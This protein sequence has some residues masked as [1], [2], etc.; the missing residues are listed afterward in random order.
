MAFLERMVEIANVKMEE[1]VAFG[2][3]HLLCIGAVILLTFLL[4]R[5][6]KDTSDKG[7]RIII[8]CLWGV[9]LMFEIYK[10]VFD[11]FEIADGSFEYVYAWSDFPFQLCSTPLFVLPF[12]GFLSDGEVRDFFASYTMT[13]GLLGGVAVY[14][15]P[16]TVFNSSVIMNVQTMVHHGIQIISGV[17][18]AAYYRRS[19]KKRFFFRGIAVFAVLFAIANLFNT[20]GYDALVSAGLL[21]EGDTFN[22]FYISPRADQST[23]MFSDILKSLDPILYI[24]GYFVVVS[25][26]GAVLMY[27]EDLVY[28]LSRKRLGIETMKL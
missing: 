17:F 6:A 21:T 20:V 1:P 13:I 10:Q 27:A 26:G 12:L 25:L 16:K 28:K 15:V 5:K 7:F 4:C 18:T 8:L 23:P 14:L 3:F 19:I 24:C 2:G 22:M 11:N 9:M